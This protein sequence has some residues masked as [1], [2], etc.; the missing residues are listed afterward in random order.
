MKFILSLHPLVQLVAIFLAYYAGYLGIQ[1]VRSLH[2]GQ[3]VAFQR[4]RHAIAGG[5]AHLVLLVGFFGGLLSSLFLH[6]H[7]GLS[8]HKLVA[9]IILPLLAV[10]LSTG[11]H[12]YRHPK[13]RNVLPIIHGVNNLILL[14]LLLFQI[15]SGW[16]LYQHNILGD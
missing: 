5:V 10:G 13:K 16:F 1:R 7:E 8:L 11:Y 14:V 3:S 15:Y 6:E 9:F 12:L 4:Q 2:L